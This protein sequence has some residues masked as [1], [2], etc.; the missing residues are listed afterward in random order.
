MC[1]S[2]LP[3]FSVS[4]N[5]FAVNEYT[6]YT[7]WWEYNTPAEY[8]GFKD[9]IESDTNYNK[10]TVQ[11]DIILPVAIRA[12]TMFDIKLDVMLSDAENITL[13]EVKLKDGNGTTIETLT[14]VTFVDGRIEAKSIQVSK[15][16]KTIRV[17]FD[18]TNP[19]WVDQFGNIHDT[20]SVDSGTVYLYNSLGALKYT[21]ENVINIKITSDGKIQVQKT[22]YTYEINYGQHISGNKNDYVVGFASTKENAQANNADLLTIGGIMEIF[23]N[24][25]IYV[26]TSQELAPPEPDPTIYMYECQWNNI[27]ITEV[28]EGGLINNIIGWIKKIYNGITSIPTK[29][30]ETANSIIESITQLPQKIADSV[31]NLFIPSEDDITEIKTDFE[32][33]LS[34]RFGAVYE[35]SDIL[36]DFATAFTDQGT[37][38]TI[39]FPSTTVHLAGA[40]FTFGGWEVDVVPDFLSGLIDVL[41]LIVNISCTFLFVNGMRKRLEGILE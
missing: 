37:Q 38:D 28:D 22:D 5:A 36:V 8:T 32:E 9:I 23:Q 31:K 12:E 34:D 16:V 6:V 33:L 1:V 24:T 30:T 7:S 21:K 17:Y 39:T 27:E 2:L 41:K 35:S 29:I 15:D 3:A 18:I 20:Y 40:E 14:G 13:R 25:D 4:A 10:I 26:I 11:T 19:T